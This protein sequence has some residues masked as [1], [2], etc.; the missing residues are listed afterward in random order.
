MQPTASPSDYA[1]AVA[2]AYWGEIYGIAMY[3]EIA[4]AQT[5]PV[6]RSHWE[7]MTELEVATEA[8]VRPLFERLGGDVT[9][10]AAEHEARGRLDGARYG[11]L[12]WPALMQR[13]SG[14]LDRVIADYG[15]IERICPPADAA[16]CRHLTE[17]EEV[18]KSFVDDELAG[19]TATSIEPVQRL[20]RQLTAAG[21]VDGSSV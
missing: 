13:F 2:A 3:T 17:H 16:V 20:I 14:A 1:D 5:D 6:R 18:A 21:G 10:H 9:A 12:T 19:R 15:A 4:A 11:A 7:T 8:R